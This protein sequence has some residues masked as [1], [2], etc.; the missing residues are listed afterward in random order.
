MSLKPYSCCL[1]PGTQVRAF[2]RRMAS[3]SRRLFIQFFM[4]L[5]VI[6]VVSYSRLLLLPALSMELRYFINCVARFL[7]REHLQRR[8]ISWMYHLQ[9][10]VVTC[11]ACLPL[12]LA[13]TPP[14]RVP[15]GSAAHRRPLRRFRTEGLQFVLL[16]AVLVSGLIALCGAVSFML[17]LCFSCAV[18]V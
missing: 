3:S 13:S 10:V 6:A 18:L 4:S 1:L 7:D 11:P 16:V 5:C 9:S 2:R 12:L 8:D 14:A 17:G 15:A